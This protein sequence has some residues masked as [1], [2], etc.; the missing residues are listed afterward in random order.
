MLSLISGSLISVWLISGWRVRAWPVPPLPA[1]FP[2]SGRPG[3]AGRFA[4]HVSPGAAA[5]AAR[6]ALATVP[7]YA[8]FAGPPPGRAP[9]AEW[10]SQ[11]PVADKKSYIDAYPL[12]ARCRHG[13]LPAAAELDESS[14][15]TGQ[16]YT[17]SGR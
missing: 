2:R 9:A 13:V 10:L 1:A 16:P 7:A 15:S 3:R 17:G 4:E 12:A 14:G 11:L 6:R 5:A 8:D